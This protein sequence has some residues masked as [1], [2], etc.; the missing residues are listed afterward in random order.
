MTTIDPSPLVSRLF[1]LKKKEDR[2]A[3]AALRTGLGY[4]PGAALA[5]APFVEP[6]LQGIPP[7]WRQD[8]HYLV[9]ALFAAHPTAGPAA[10]ERHRNLGHDL[11]RLSEKTGSE[12]IERRFMA[13][14]N[15]SKDNLPTHLRHAISLLRA[16]DITPDWDQLLKDLQWWPRDDRKIQRA[17]AKGYWG[18]RQEPEAATATA[19]ETTPASPDPDYED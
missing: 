12:S 13:L 7:G 19:P 3:L 16:N 11:R 4:P 18:F 9:A 14:L 15:T 1:G 2:A 17:W 8:A 6:F 10:A 5:M